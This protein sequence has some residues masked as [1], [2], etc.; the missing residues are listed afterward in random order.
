MWG[1][2]CTPLGLRRDMIVHSQ[3]DVTREEEHG[4]SAVSMMFRAVFWDILPCKMVV[5][6][7]FRGAYCLHHQGWVIPTRQYIP[8]DSSEHHTHRCENLKSN[9]CFHVKLELKDWF[10][11]R[12]Q[13]CLEL[14][15]A[16]SSKRV[17]K[18]TVEVKFINYH[19]DLLAGN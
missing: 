4:K 5:D 12:R 19:Q 17:I 3:F 14:P 9:S 7:R 8:E 16:V 6:R 13:T 2:K 18:C 11:F 1:K 15:K 10:N